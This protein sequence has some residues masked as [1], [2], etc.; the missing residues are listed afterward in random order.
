[1]AFPFEYMEHVLFFVTVSMTALLGTLILGGAVRQSTMSSTIRENEFS[2]NKFVLRKL[3]FVQ[4][5][6]IK[7]L[8]VCLAKKTFCYE[9]KGIFSHK[10]RLITYSCF[11]GR[12]ITFRSDLSFISSQDIFDTYNSYFSQFT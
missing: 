10:E 12:F 5:L 8:R 6:K 11:L 3:T 7:S 4:T 9:F 1:M 2:M